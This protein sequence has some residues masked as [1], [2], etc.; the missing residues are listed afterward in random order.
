ML[1]I[2]ITET[3]TEVRCVLQGRLFGPWVSELRTIWRTVTLI[4]K[5]HPC[6]VD[7]SDVTLIDKRGEELLRAMSEEGAQFTANDLYVKHLLEGLKVTG[8][9]G[10]SE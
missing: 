2:T 4:C 6:I 5:G 7:L 9:C 1:R 3:P 10:L 8:K